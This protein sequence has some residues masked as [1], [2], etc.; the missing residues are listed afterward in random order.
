MSITPITRSGSAPPAASARE[1]PELYDARHWETAYRH[2]DEDAVP[3]LLLHLQDD[4]TRSRRR[5]AA[6]LSVIVHLLV[7]ILFVNQ[8]RL[9]GFYRRVFLHQQPVMA[10][11]LEDLLRQK[12]MTYLELPPDVQKI[13]KRPDT[14]IAS[15]KDRIATTRTPQLDPKELK[16][17]IDAS[18]PG[19]PGPSAPPSPGQAPEMAQNS[20]GPQAPQPGQP[21]PQTPAP[22]QLAQLQP[23]TPRPDP[24]VKF[25]G[26]MSAGSAIEQAARAASQSRGAYG[27]DGGDYGL[28][29]G[30]HNGALGPLEILSDTMG[31]DF[32]SYL[33]RVLHE[34]KQQWYELIPE[35]ATLKK[36]KVVLEF[37]ILKDGS[38]A[39]L[40]LVGS[41]GDVALDRPAYGSITGSNPFPPLPREFAGPY[42]LLRFSYYYNLN[43]DGSDLR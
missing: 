28:N 16:K 19:T 40:K 32:G 39:G 1:A 13:T 15:D 30:R 31:V 14:R 25:G 5:E 18:R 41:S 23:P 9:E 35:S 22:D 24:Q 27:G 20:P 11:S 8:P 4:L 12:E 2:F 26:S 38:V 36:G 21:T 34:V 37:A 33:N 42:L 10:V 3:Q 43:I 7:I 17:I 6:W 29:Q